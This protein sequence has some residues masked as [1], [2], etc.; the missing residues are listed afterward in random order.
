MFIGVGPRLCP[1]PR[2]PQRVEKVDVAQLDVQERPET[3]PK[4]YENVVFSP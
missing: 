1:V 4:H 2:I 3:R